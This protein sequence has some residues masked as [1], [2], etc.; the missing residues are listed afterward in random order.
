[1]MRIAILIL[2]LCSFSFQEFC[3]GGINWVHLHIPRQSFVSYNFEETGH[4]LHLNCIG[5]RIW[6]QFSGNPKY[7]LELHNKE[8]SYDIKQFFNSTY[9]RNFTAESESS[10]ELRFY[11]DNTLWNADLEISIH[12]RI[13][14]CLPNLPIVILKNDKETMKEGDMAFIDSSA[15]LPPLSVELCTKEAA[16]WK[17]EFEFKAYLEVRLRFRSC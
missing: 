10:W 9:K 11:N 14:N 7:R 8:R 2:C 6:D 16:T 13:D 1:M 12:Y 5:G 15:N 17:L 4:A 3:S